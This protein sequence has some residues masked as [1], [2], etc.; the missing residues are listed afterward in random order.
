[1]VEKRR[2]LSADELPPG[3]DGHQRKKQTTER[4]MASPT[5][6]SAQVQPAIM[7]VRPG[8]GL[9]RL[10][11]ASSAGSDSARPMS[12]D[13]PTPTPDEAEAEDA[14][15]EVDDE[16]TQ[17]QE[18]PLTPPTHAQSSVASETN[19]DM[20][21]DPSGNAKLLHAAL[22]AASGTSTPDV[23]PF[24]EDDATLMFRHFL[25]VMTSKA[26]VVTPTLADA[27]GCE[28][29]IV[30]YPHGVVDSEYV[31]VFVQMVVNERAG[32]GGD[33]DG[34]QLEEEEVVRHAEVEIILLHQQ[35]ETGQSNHVRTSA[36]HAFSRETHE[37][38][39]S[40][41]IRRSQLLN[42]ENAFLATDSR[43]RVDINLHF[44]DPDPLAVKTDIDSALSNDNMA[45]AMAAQQLQLGPHA[46]I[47]LEAATSAVG[48]GDANV[49]DDSA[50]SMRQLLAYDSKQE[51]GMVGLKNQ[52]AT[53]YLN[54]LLQTLFH[55]RAFRQ[56]VYETPTQNEDTTNSVSLALQRVFY[57]LQMQNKAVSTKELTRS[58]GWSQIDSFMQHDVQ[59]LYRIL[60][61]RLEEKM[62]NTMVD[63]AIKR[64]FEGKVRSFVRCVDVDF[65]SFRDESF[66]DLQLDVKGC[67]DIYESF[68]KYV[69]IELLQGDNQ[70]EAEGYGKQDAKKGVS[71]LQLPP[72]LNIQLKRY[73]YDPMRDGM[74]KIHDRFEYPKTLIL[75]EFLQDGEVTAAE[76]DGKENDKDATLAGSEGTAGHKHIYHLHSV[77][78]HSGDV[79]GGHYYV[80]I[81]PGKDISNS[82]DWFRFDD[83]QITRVDENV[84]IEGNFGSAPSTA[85]GASRPA[86]PMYSSSLISSPDP[87]AA[88]HEESGLEFRSMDMPTPEDKDQNG[89][90]D[91][92]YEYSRSDG[93][94]GAPGAQPF[95]SAESS[96]SN[97]LTLPLVRSFSSAYMLVYVRDGNNDISAIGDPAKAE[98]VVG[99]TPTSQ[100]VEMTEAPTQPVDEDTDAVTVPA[101]LVERFQKEEKAAARRKKIQQTE[102]LFM[103]L[104]V[105]SDTSVSS[106]RRF[107]K[108]VDFSQ[109]GNS[110]CL[111]IRM[112]RTGSIRELY[113]RIYKRTGVPVARQRLWK[114]ITRE[115]RTHRPDQP[116]LSDVL[117]FRV[118][119]LIDDDASPKAPVRLYLQIVSPSSTGK[120]AKCVVNRHVWSEFTPPESETE[121]EEGSQDGEDEELEE[122]VDTGGD[123]TRGAAG[124]SASISPG[125]CPALLD[126]HDIL[127][128]V[129]FYDLTRALGDRLQYMGNIIID[130]RRTG[131]ELATFL[132]EALQIPTSKELIL[133]EE[134]QPTSVQEIEMGTTLTVAE[135][136]HGD[137]I[138]YQYAEDEARARGSLVIHPELVVDEP[139][140]DLDVKLV[141]QD[142]ES[143]LDDVSHSISSAV[144][145]P[146]TASSNG[147][148]SSTGD[149][150][151][152]ASRAAVVERYPDVP[153]YFRYLLDRVEIVFQRYGHA[154]EKFVLELLN[155]N[156]YDE[157]IDAVAAHLGFHGDKRLHLRLYQ[158][159]PLN[160]MPM[161][162]PLRHSRYAGDSQTTLEEFL[163]EYLERTTTMYYEV[164]PCPI[165]E[166]EAKKQVLVYLSA[167]DDCFV[168]PSAPRGHSR[169]IEFL[170]MPT[171][172]ARNLK[173]LVRE[174]FELPESVKLRVCEVVQHGTMVRALLGDDTP[175][176]RFWAGGAGGSAPSPSH[177][178]SEA[179]TL[180]IECVPENEVEEEGAPTDAQMKGDDS[181][182]VF[183]KG[184][185][186]FNFQIN[187]PTW[188]HPH[189]VPLVVRFREQE[190]IAQVKARIRRR[191]ATVPRLHP[192]LT[193]CGDD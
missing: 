90:A 92:V 173:E 145:A 40:K 179:S 24:T 45:M 59:E 138:C 47:S 128:F 33:S 166:I 175:L 38:G 79:H 183:Y 27:L 172:T 142:E 153:S 160:G 36:A 159:S 60:C 136:Q 141:S 135:I 56:V 151:H 157:I 187:S 69:E 108:S 64:L 133:Y 85:A 30:W 46:G 4:D 93:I 94:V 101:E 123:A 66:Y 67:K 148:S 35:D 61:D 81:R 165:T 131:A 177:G 161:R 134:I 149:G 147:N 143:S 186:H 44:V 146:D 37:F 137:I 171:D 107:T 52:G 109:F 178:S 76:K 14:A 16:A 144:F 117:D 74:V 189:G 140:P 100:D 91:D 31:S 25:P 105:A 180:F 6:S 168:D 88:A 169:R 112:K 191:F 152:G 9:N 126:E 8:S 10:A 97:G 34:Q 78:V 53:C 28:W 15:M 127:L 182:E 7:A 23:G 39:V 106:L 176:D 71:F 5:S 124:R 70:Y 174:S 80:F 95:L 19:V 163:T 68:R 77:L 170:V 58:F 1:M 26:R 188:I 111:R 102:H 87:A 118:E 13:L 17:S 51:T 114:V 120:A 99:Q 18:T 139:D 132:H 184:I 55:L 75:D 192:V 119:S 96:S 72:V 185:V 103:N 104:R 42:P 21:L 83:D 193:R 41:F 32:G 65:Q 50:D 49:A 11:G 167:Y 130:A 84:A 162:S 122:E 62:K 82:S 115:N 158:H 3:D 48:D 73:E 125:C 54:S 57:R 150:K 164:L 154:D 129:K 98:A 63:S 86:S 29:R 43:V 155:S 116:L 113:R 181:N 156:V 2:S 22:A 20:K 12:V 89:S 190:T 110:T 121:K